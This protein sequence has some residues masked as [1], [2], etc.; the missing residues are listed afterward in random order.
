MA[1]AKSHI[2]NLIVAAMILVP[3][4]TSAQNAVFEKLA[5]LPDVE[6]TYLSSAMLSN[7]ENLPQ[8]SININKVLSQLNSIEV[9]T[10]DEEEE[11]YKKI[12]TDIQSLYGGMKLISRVQDGTNITQIFGMPTKGGESSATYSEILFVN[13]DRDS[14]EITAILFTGK[15][16]PDAIKDLLDD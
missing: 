9:L 13:D 12:S 6:Y 7:A 3:A 15:I 16:Q 10:S 5:N 1:T 11:S 14:Q 4:I 8:T 2:K